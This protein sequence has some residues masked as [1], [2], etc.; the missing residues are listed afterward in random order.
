MLLSRHSWFDAE[1]AGLSAP[2]AAVDPRRRTRNVGAT[3]A[4]IR[5]EPLDVAPIDPLPLFGEA[6][7]GCDPINAR[8][9]PAMSPPV[10]A[11]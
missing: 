2:S 8:N 6:A 9:R 5:T 11:E 4:V 3:V 1:T 10:A 7:A